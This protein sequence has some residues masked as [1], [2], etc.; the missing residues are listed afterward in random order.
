MHPVGSDIRHVDLLQQLPPTIILQHL[1][2]LNGNLIKFY[3]PSNLLSAL[4]ISESRY[5]SLLS[6]FD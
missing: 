2:L 6:N 4:L 5:D 3:G 1:H